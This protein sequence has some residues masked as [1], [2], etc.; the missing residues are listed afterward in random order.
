MVE[1]T[2]KSLV[3]V[4]VPNISGQLAIVT[5]FCAENNINILRLTLSAADRYDKIQKIIMYLEGSRVL[6]NDVCKKLLEVET[7]I[8]VSNFQTNSQ[9]IEKEVCL[10]KILIKNPRFQN[11]M[12]L[13]SDSGGRIVHS[14]GEITIFEIEN[15]EENVNK[16]VN[17]MADITKD[18][19]ISRSGMVAMALDS[20]M[21]SLIDVNL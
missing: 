3:T 16:L 9:F 4:L 17:D 8:K 1:E 20:I 6:V 12:A 21:D 5:K 2:E 18:I 19:E 11:V 15:N 13:I 7:I 10:I 14:N